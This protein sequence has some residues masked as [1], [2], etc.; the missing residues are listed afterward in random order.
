MVNGRIIASGKSLMFCSASFGE[1]NRFDHRRLDQVLALTLH[2]AFDRVQGKLPTSIASCN[3][4]QACSSSRKC[5]KQKPCL[6]SYV[7]SNWPISRPQVRYEHGT[8][9]AAWDCAGGLK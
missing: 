9:F 8:D 7:G 6:S 3:V 5:G 4:K 1:A 2:M